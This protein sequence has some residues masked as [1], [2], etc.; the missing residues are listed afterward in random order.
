LALRLAVFAGAAVGAALALLPCFSF[1][2]LEDF[3][4]GA[5][6]ALG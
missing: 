3:R 5:L 4:V 6:G 2:L 1:L